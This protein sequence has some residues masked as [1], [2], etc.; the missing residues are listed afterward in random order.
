MGE[1]RGGKYL[2]GEQNCFVNVKYNAF[3]H[4]LLIS[5]DFKNKY[6]KFTNQRRSHSLLS[7]KRKAI[8]LF[9][10]RSDKVPHQRPL[11][12]LEQI[13][14]RG[15]VLGWMECFLIKPSQKVVLES[16][17]SEEVSVSSGVPQ[18]TVLAPLLF[19][20]L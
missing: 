17:S 20:L 14:I 18:G 6:L 5:N 7:I 16:I 19:L 4:L 10:Q 3:N 8:F 12:K 15:N 11:L 2:S 1:G 13:G 9:V